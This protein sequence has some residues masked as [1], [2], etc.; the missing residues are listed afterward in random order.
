MLSLFGAFFSAEA[1]F[2]DYAGG[3]RVMKRMMRGTLFDDLSREHYTK[4]VPLQQRF[5][6]LMP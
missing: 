5:C 1:R 6:K 4:N 2:L 3:F